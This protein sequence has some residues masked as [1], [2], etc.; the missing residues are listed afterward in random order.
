MSPALNLMKQR[1]DGY[2][3]SDTETEWQESPWNDP[4]E[5]KIVLDY[6]NRR[7]GSAVS[8]KFSAAANVSPPGLRRN[9]GRTPYRPAK[10]DSALVMLQ[11]NISPMSRAERRRHESP[12][13]AAAED[14][15]SSSMRARK[16]EKLTYTHGGN[17][18]SQKP[19]YNRRSATA[20]RLRM[21][22]EQP[23]TV[24]NLSQRRERAAPSLQVN[25]SIQQQRDVSQVN[26][27][28]VGEMNEMIAD[29]RIY[30]GPTF[31]EP[32]VESTGSISPGDIFFSRDS[33]AIGMN[34]NVSAKRNAFLNYT[35]PKPK[36][37]SKK[38]GDTYNQVNANVD[39]NG[40]GISSS[41]TTTTN[42]A[43]VSRENSYR[44]STES[45]KISDV[46][47][48][49]SE[50]TRRFIASRR[51][52]KNELWFSCMRNG[53]CRTTKSPEKRPLDEASFIEKA[54]VVEYLRPFWAD[55]HQPVSLNGFTFHKH[56]AQ[57]LKQLVSFLRQDGFFNLLLHTSTRSHTCA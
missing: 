56:E 38:N 20:P 36:F 28:S 44:I 23:N 43:A 5:K 40:R 1:K 14:I 47:G 50:S 49:T 51:K 12:F 8:K 29:G 9:G 46:S 30:G 15:G 24:N 4:K 22:D 48:R 3:P 33:L 57:L 55:Q 54:N 42:S 21:R 18:I 10:D 2:E 7:T 32:V 19:S 45:S 37:M 35:S 16:D 17:K 6:D 41:G 13:K 52:K 27:M 53:T 26:S 31:N 25:Y 39:L 34:N 11:R